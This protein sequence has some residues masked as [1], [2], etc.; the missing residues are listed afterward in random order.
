MLNK[1]RLEYDAEMESLFELCEAGKMGTVCDGLKDS[2]GRARCKNSITQKTSADMS[3]MVPSK[4]S[5]YRRHH[6]ERHLYSFSPV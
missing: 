5:C 6:H 3:Q 2:S 1:T 4:I